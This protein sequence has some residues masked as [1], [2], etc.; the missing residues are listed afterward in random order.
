MKKVIRFLLLALVVS[1]TTTSLYAQIARCA[2]FTVVAFPL[3]P[4]GGSNNYFGVRVTL[5]RTYDQNVT[6]TGYIYDEGSPNQNTPYTVVVSSGN[7]SNETAATFYQTDPASLAVVSVTSASPTIVTSGG[8]KFNTQCTFSGSSYDNFDSYFS[9]IGALHN[10]LLSAAWANN[11]LP[12]N[13]STY[14]AAINDFRDAAKSSFLSNYASYLDT[15]ISSTPIDEDFERVKYF[16]DNTEFISNL[17]TSSHINS[18]DSASIKINAGSDITSSNKALF[19]DIIAVVDSSLNNLL[20]NDQ[21]ENSLARLANDWVSINTGDEYSLSA[22]L[23][24]GIISTGLKSCEWWRDN[25]SAFDYEESIALSR[26]MPM[27]DYVRNII[28][29]SLD[30]RNSFTPDNEN[31]VKIPYIADYPQTKK[32]TYFL[33]PVVGLDIAG[34]I[35]GGVSSWFTQ[36]FFTGHAKGKMVLAG[37]VT[38]AFIA[39]TGIVGR[40]GGWI[41]SLRG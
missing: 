13:A 29:A 35:V 2:D 10:Q 33:L 3:D 21:F 27:N 40:L 9:N 11:S 41:N 26:S 23:T 20:T 8:L 4:Q 39:S 5:T 22:Q 7:T 36:K 37:A 1:L 14:G 19:D 31:A 38:G 25:P 16:F 6:V 12:T 17:L 15:T 18:L 34:A 28:D 30:N 24:G 32:T